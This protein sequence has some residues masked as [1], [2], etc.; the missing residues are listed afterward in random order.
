MCVW[1]WG[2]DYSRGCVGEG[3]AV[4]V[5]TVGVSKRGGSMG[6]DLSLSLGNKQRALV[7]ALKVGYTQAYLKWD[8]HRHT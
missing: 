1:A 5:V 7:D 3:V 2:C 6:C 8:I 4:G